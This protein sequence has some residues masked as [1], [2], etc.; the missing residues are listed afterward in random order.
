MA[1]P[2]RAEASEASASG[3]V[4]AGQHERDRI[5]RERPRLAASV[6]EEEPAGIVNRRGGGWKEGGSSAS[7]VG[8]DRGCSLRLQGEI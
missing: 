3:V 5:H 2:V 8:E 1:D 6:R 4:A 7:E